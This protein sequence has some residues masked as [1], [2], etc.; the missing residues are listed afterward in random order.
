[1]HPSRLSRGEITKLHETWPGEACDLIL[2]LRDLLLEV[3]P[4]LSEMI[5]FKALCDYRPNEPY[6]VIGGNVCLIAPRGDCEHLGFIHGAFLPNPEGLPQ[7]TAK[8]KRHIELRSTSDIQRSAFRKLLRAAI[9]HRP[10]G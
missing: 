10:C 6:D 8:A 1:M 3:G 9:A 4:E 7:G 2:E 5:A